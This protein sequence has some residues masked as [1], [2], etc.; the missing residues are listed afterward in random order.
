MAALSIISG[1]F[2]VATVGN[3]VLNGLQEW[4]VEETVDRLDGTTGGDA[5][6]ENDDMGVRA[7]E[8]R[9]TLVQNLATGKY[10]EIMA[11][12]I[13]TEVRLYRSF[14]DNVPAFYFPLM[15]VYQS[16]N[17]GRVRDRFMV[18]VTARSNGSYAVYNPGSG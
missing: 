5:G 14:T 11:G 12:T 16:R 4:E 2:L 10:A 3:V 17:G 18:N 1:K 8:A 6:F 7:A 9:F 15:R 13:L